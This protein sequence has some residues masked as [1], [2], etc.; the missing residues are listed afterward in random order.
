MKTQCISVLTNYF[1]SLGKRVML[2][3]PG[4]KPRDEL[5]KRYKLLYNETIPNI[6]RE[7]RESKAVPII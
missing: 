6:L 2:I 1:H 5:I 4:S 7:I 3:T